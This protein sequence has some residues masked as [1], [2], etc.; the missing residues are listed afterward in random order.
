MRRFKKLYWLIYDFENGPVKLKN[1]H[2]H[3]TSDILGMLEA[4]IACDKS[5]KIAEE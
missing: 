3:S 1:T 4:M 2:K 5:D